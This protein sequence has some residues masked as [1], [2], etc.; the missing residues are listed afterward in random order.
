MK[1]HFHYIP[2]ILGFILLL[3]LYLIEKQGVF[4]ISVL[5]YSLTYLLLTLGFPLYI[6][7]EAEKIRKKGKYKTVYRLAFV[8]GLFFYVFIENCIRYFLIFINA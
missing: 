5:L 6:F 1:K 7:V 3:A 4:T 8:A 2:M